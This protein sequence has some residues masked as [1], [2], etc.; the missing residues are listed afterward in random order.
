MFLM[1]PTRSAWPI[2]RLTKRGQMRIR[3]ADFRLGYKLSVAKRKRFSAESVANFPQITQK[4]QSHFE[5][6]F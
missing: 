4:F 1:P 2:N 3:F 6:R 5:L